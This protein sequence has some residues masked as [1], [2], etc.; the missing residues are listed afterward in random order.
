[1]KRPYPDGWCKTIEALFKE[2]R[3]HS[4][5]EIEWARAYEREQLKEKGARFP[6]SGEIYE[7]VHDVEVSCMTH[8][9]APFTGGKKVIL[10]AGTK[11]KV[12]GHPLVPEPISV[13]TS[14]LDSE[15]LEVIFVNQSDR[16]SEQYAGYSISV[17]T[18]QLN[19]DFRLVPEQVT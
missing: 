14:P 6:M 16:E 7:A 11:I 9:R 12:E 5:Q 13:Y 19:S 17:K 4:G 10:P 2:R 3:K 1:M 15:R 8:W 18:A